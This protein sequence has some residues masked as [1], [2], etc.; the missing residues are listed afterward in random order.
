[1]LSPGGDI[2]RR[3]QITTAIDGRTEKLRLRQLT[4]VGHVDG[5]AKLNT[6]D[7]IPDDVLPSDRYRL[8]Q[9]MAEYVRGAINRKTAK[10]YPPGYTLIVG[11]DDNTFDGEDDAARFAAIACPRN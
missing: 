11:F 9:E 2:A 10:S 7:E 1:L 4:R 5:L 3:F 8:I 6:N